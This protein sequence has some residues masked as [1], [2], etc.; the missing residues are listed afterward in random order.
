MKDEHGRVLIDGF[1]DGINIDPQTKKILAAVPDNTNE[2][3]RRLVIAEE[4]KVGSNYQESLQF[5]SLT[6]S[7]MRAAVVGIGAGSIIPEESVAV[8]GIRLVPE[9]DGQ[10]MIDLVK[11]HLEKLGYTVLDHV[12]AVEERLKYPSIVYFNGRAGSPAF[13]TELNSPISSWLQKSITSNFGS[14]PVIIRIMGGSVPIVPFVQALNIPA[15]IVPLVNADNN[16]H[17]PNENLRLGNLRTGIKVC[18]SI[19][20]SPIQSTGSSKTYAYQK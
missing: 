14:D 16:Q 13:R 8:F 15:V 12:P 19:L 20:S 17:S 10:R 11:K 6:I 5:P 7:G 2:I 1:Y 3:N 4:E 9:T 18:L